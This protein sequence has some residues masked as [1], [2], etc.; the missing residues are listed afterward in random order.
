MSSVPLLV[1]GVGAKVGIADGLLVGAK[2]GS[3]EGLKVGSAE[4]GSLVLIGESVG[5]EITA[6]LPFVGCCVGVELV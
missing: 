4:V 6:L 3:A 5:L 1:V 2:V